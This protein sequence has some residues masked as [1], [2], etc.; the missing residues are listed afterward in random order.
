M[1]FNNFI[2]KKSQI[3]VFLIIGLIILIFLLFFLLIYNK[4]PKPDILIPESDEFTIFIEECLFITAQEA[5]IK[6]GAGGGYIDFHEVYGIRPVTNPL[7]SESLN[8]FNSMEL[9]YWLYQTSNGVDRQN[10]PALQKSFDND[11][12]IQWQIENYINN[13]IRYCFRNFMAFKDK[14]INVLEKTTPKSEILFTNNNVIAKL[15]YNVELTTPNGI[16]T[17][18]NNY[19][20][21]I[22]IA[23]K[24]VYSFAKDITIYQAENAFIED[25]LLDLISIYSRTDKNYLPPLY[26]FMMQPCSEYVFWSPIQVKEM[27][28]EML[29]SNIP[30][31]SITNGEHF[32]YDVDETEFID[33]E[34][35]EIAK[36][37]M[38]KFKNSVSSNNYPGILTHLSYMEDFPLELDFGVGLIEPRNLEVDLIFAKYCFFEYRTYYTTAF[39]VLFTLYDSNSIVNNKEGYLF[40]FP[41]LAVLKDNFPRVNYRTNID[42]ITDE[43][44]TSYQCNI[45]QRISGDVSVKVNDEFGKPIKDVMVLFRCGPSFVYDYDNEGNIISSKKFAENCVI[46]N[47][48]SDGIMIEKFPPCVGAGVIELKSQTHSEYIELV[49][50]ILEEEEYNFEFNLLKLVELEISINKYDTDGKVG[51]D[52]DYNIFDCVP[53]FNPMPL[54]ANENVIIKLELIE[55]LDGHTITSSPFAFYN[56]KEK[57]NISLVPGIY[58][59]E[60]ML[61]RN[62]RYPGEMTIKKN[63]QSKEVD[64][65]P[66]GGTE[67]IYYPEEDIEMA[68]AITGGASFIFEVTSNDLHNK[69]NIKFFIFDMGIPKT[70]EKIGA[71]DDSSKFCSDKHKGRITPVIS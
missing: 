37:V 69:K 28:R 7:N 60:I 63:S 1:N 44:Y 19:Q 52:S 5:I 20:T 61:M 13:N 25:T 39:P 22:P 64:K 67:T 32:S 50:D 21:Q 47:T 33:D 11:Y 31:I 3:T 66:L 68:M 8:L 58:Q 38:N 26:N 51:V 41:L 4:N 57:S 40:Q 54:E 30:F 17:N 18:Y 2:N 34:E 53:D 71:A 48:N 16:I 55:S 27:F 10:I 14:K 29:A 6:I 59:A 56:P 12:S 65:G 24:N 43:E 70:I 45:E 36:G 62:E 46:G 42:S 35:I 9:P 15:N 23:L 49:G